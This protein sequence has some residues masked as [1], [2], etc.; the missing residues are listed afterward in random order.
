[1]DRV[2]KPGQGWK[3]LTQLFL[4]YFL[5]CKSLSYGLYVDSY[6]PMMKTLIGVKAS[7]T[8][9][10]YVVARAPWAMKPIW[11][12]ISDV[13]PIQGYRKRYYILIAVALASIGLVYPALITPSSGQECAFWFFLFVAGTTICDSMTQ[14]R[15]TELMKAAGNASVVNFVWFLISACGLLAFYNLLLPDSSEKDLPD[16]RYKILLWIAVPCCVPMLYPA[17]MNWLAEEQGEETRCTANTAI[18]KKHPRIFVLAATTAII[19]LGGVVVQLSFSSIELWGITARW[20][21]GFYYCGAAVVIL[22]LCQVC[23]PRSIALPCVYMFIC[24]AWFLNVGLIL[25]YWYTAP[26]QCFDDA[27]GQFDLGPEFEVSYYQM[28][29]GYGGT[30]ASLAGVIIFD[31]TIQFWNVRAAFWFTTAVNA[32]TTIF[33][34]MIVERWNQKLFGYDPNVNRNTNVDRAFFILGAQAID[35]L[36]DMLDSLP[37]TVLIGKLCPKGMEAQVFAILAA[38][39]NFGSNVAY[40]NGSIVAQVLGVKLTPPSGD[41]DGWTCANPPGPWGISS[42]GWLKLLATFFLPLA[43]VPFTWCFLPNVNLN[44]DMLGEEDEAQARELE[45]MGGMPEGAGQSFT[46]TASKDG[47]MGASKSKD[48]NMWTTV[49]KGSLV[50][51]GGSQLF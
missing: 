46:G 25:Q 30:L 23:L 49:S 28:I 16:W 27:E 37:Q 15:Y 50:K 29:S 8:N 40:I 7:D 5:F 44:D 20:Y 13:L 24:K 2:T 31:R 4:T 48:E 26:K 45:N 3:V 34:L 17:A 42:L 10:L 41:N 9:D 18:I 14:A 19:A 1:M 35:K 36:L 39:S 51:V 21:N 47:G 22:L 43:T 33:E 6:F 12:I 32:L 38:L 11:A